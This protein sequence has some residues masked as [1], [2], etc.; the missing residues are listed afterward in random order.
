MNEVKYSISLPEHVAHADRSL[1]DAQKEFERFTGLENDARDLLASAQL[2]YELAVSDFIN[3][4]KSEGSITVLKEIARGE[5]KE[6]Y[7][8]YVMAETNLKKVQ[9]GK[10]LNEQRM[11]TAKTLLK[12][13]MGD[14]G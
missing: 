9:A 11:M 5:C 3:K 8:A 6:L 7:T 2:G 1:V 4:N 13:K 14:M 10:T 12:L